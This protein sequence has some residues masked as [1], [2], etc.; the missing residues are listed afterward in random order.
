MA[1]NEPQNIIWRTSSMIYLK[2][3]RKACP[4]LAVWQSDHEKAGQRHSK[5]LLYKNLLLT[6][7][8]DE[9]YYNINSLRW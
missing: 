1:T 3:L 9:L 2:A 8:L 5:S 6:I 4:I 7:Y